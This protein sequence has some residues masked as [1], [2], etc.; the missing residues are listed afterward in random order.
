MRAHLRYRRDDPR[1]YQDIAE[2]QDHTFALAHDE[3]LVGH[4]KD[5]FGLCLLLD[6]STV[7]FNPSSHLKSGKLSYM[8]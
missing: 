5:S 6:R 1:V 4:I 3:A 8:H 7:A 2:R